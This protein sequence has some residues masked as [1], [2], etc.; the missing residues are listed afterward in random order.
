MSEDLIY[1]ALEAKVKQCK[2]LITAPLLILNLNADNEHFKMFTLIE[3]LSLPSALVI[4]PTGGCT[5]FCNEIERSILDQIRNHVDV[6]TFSSFQ[7]LIL[8]MEGIIPKRSELLIETSEKISKLDKVSYGT[9]SKLKNIFNLQSAEGCL[10]K[11]RSIKTDV[12]IQL[13]NEAVKKTYTILDEIESEIRPNNT[14]RQIANSLMIKTIESRLKL[15][16]KPIVASGVRAKDPHPY[17]FTDMKL[18]KDDVVIVDFGVSYK[19]Y[20][21]DIT[22]SYSMKVDREEL[23]FHEVFEE[24]FTTLEKLKITE[25]TPKSLAI[26]MERIVDEKAVKKYVKHSYGHGIGIEVH[27]VYPPISTYPSVLSEERLSN[28]VTFAFEPAFYTS[29]LGIRIE[30]D[31][32]IEDNRARNLVR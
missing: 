20:V 14:E 30:K 11:L 12:E 21:S 2:E 29:K 19:G 22:R 28:N 27:D 16:F 18:K 3:D 24:M 32:V 10:I 23:P 15:S 6:I 4:T 7:D 5:L 9:Y 31:Y 1:S 13:I 8:K 26:E 25:Y 17:P